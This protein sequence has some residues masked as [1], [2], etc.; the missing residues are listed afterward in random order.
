M[1]ATL[2]VHHALWAGAGLELPG[3]DHELDE[4]TR[5]QVEHLAHAQSAGALEIV[6]VDRQAAAV[7]K[8]AVESQ[9]QS[10]RQLAKAIADGRWQEGHQAQLDSEAMS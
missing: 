1:R 10:E 4:L 3:G 7:I 9:E 8:K 5:E 2:H 6:D